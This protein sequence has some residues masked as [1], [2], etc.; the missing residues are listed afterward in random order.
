MLRVTDCR[1]GGFIFP[2]AM[3]ED[4]DVAKH[5]PDK[6]AVVKKQ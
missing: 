6:D 4:E 2:H 1:C 3:T 5:V